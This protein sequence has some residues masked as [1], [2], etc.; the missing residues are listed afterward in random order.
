MSRRIAAK[1]EDDDESMDDSNYVVSRKAGDADAKQ[2][3]QKH[4][5]P[6]WLEQQSTSSRKA[7]PT[8]NAFGFDDGEPEGSSLGTMV[9]GGAA[10]LVKSR[11][12]NHLRGNNNKSI[13]EA[14]GRSHY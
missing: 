7:T 12:Y 13:D 4:Q 14:P 9:G 10:G 1:G 6:I 3:K 2:Q 5:Q 11:R 8:T